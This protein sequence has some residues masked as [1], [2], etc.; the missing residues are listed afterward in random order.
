MIFCR[1]FSETTAIWY[2][3]L[4]VISKIRNITERGRTIILLYLYFYTLY[5][6]STRKKNIQMK[7]NIFISDLDDRICYF[8][9]YGMYRVRGKIFSCS[10]WREFLNDDTYEV[11]KRIKK[12]L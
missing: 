6:P 10:Y 4:I 9:N 3:S 11:S 5:V 8:I 12:E 7:K 2:I 1:K